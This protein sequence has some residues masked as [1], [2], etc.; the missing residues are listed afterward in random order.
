MT[1]T[2]CRAG[3]STQFQEDTGLRRYDDMGLAE[4]PLPVNP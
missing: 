1:K 2:P 3:G 4:T